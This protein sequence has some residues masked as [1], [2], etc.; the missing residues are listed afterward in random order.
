[1]GF[2][3]MIFLGNLLN[4]SGWSKVFGSRDYLLSLL[5]LFNINHIGLSSFFS[6][7]SAFPVISPMGHP[8]V[9]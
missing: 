6:D 1:V 5:S 7:D 3:S 2:E 4:S 8:L 9:N